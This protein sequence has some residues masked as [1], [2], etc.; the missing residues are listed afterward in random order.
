MTSPGPAATDARVFF[1]DDLP[2]NIKDAR[3]MG[4]WSENRN[5]YKRPKLASLWNR[6]K[7]GM[8][9]TPPMREGVGSAVIGRNLYIFGGLGGADRRSNNMFRLDLETLRWSPIVYNP[10]KGCKPPDARSKHTLAAEGEHLIVFASACRRAG[11]RAGGRT[12]VPRCIQTG[13]LGDASVVSFFVVQR[14]CAVPVPSPCLPL[15]LGIS[16]PLLFISWTDLSP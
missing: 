13:P 6:R 7:A 10:E 5:I 8:Q 15:S 3:R 2:A 16:W 1:Q 11:R 9:R 4:Q 14:V 12:D